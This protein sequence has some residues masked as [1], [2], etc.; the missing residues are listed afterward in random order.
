M[1]CRLHPQIGIVT[2]KN[3]SMEKLNIDIE[4]K[5]IP[6]HSYD[7]I[8]FLS[9]Q[10]NQKLKNR[11]VHNQSLRKL[12]TYITTLIALTLS[13]L[14]NV[15]LQFCLRLKLFMLL[16]LL[17]LE[18]VLVG[19]S[20][21]HCCMVK[22]VFFQIHI[23]SSLEASCWPTFVEGIFGNRVLIAFT[24]YASIKTLCQNFVINMLTCSQLLEGLNASSS[25]KHRKKEESRHAPQLTTLRRVEGRVGASGW[26]QEELTS[27]THSHRHAHNSHKVVSAQLEHPWCQDEPWATR[28]HQTHHSPN[29][30]EA[31]TFPLIIYYVPLHKAHIQMAFCPRTPKWESQNCQSQESHDFGA[32]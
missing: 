13:N 21:K 29:L 5:I 12:T 30:G 16:L 11:C 2:W 23:K 22:C 14:F 32:P 24:F 9:I 28:T 8:H 31:T 6:S 19:T 4:H 20:S 18:I 7:Y 27:F 10:F 25:R 26:D 1:H 15:F 17:G 3:Q